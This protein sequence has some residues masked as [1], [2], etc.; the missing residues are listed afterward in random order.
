MWKVQQRLVRVMV[1]VIRDV[2]AFKRRGD[3][4][5][6]RPLSTEELSEA[7]RRWIEESQVDFER[8]ES[9]RSL[10]SQLNLFRDEDSLWHCDGRLANTELPYSTK[11][12]LLLP[13]NHSLTPLIIN[14]AHRRVLHEWRARDLDRNPKKILD[15]KGEEFGPSNSTPMCDLSQIRRCPVS[16]TTPTSFA[17]K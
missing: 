16:S 11:Y 2:K 4:Q 3:S 5:S 10:K 13:R 14:D 9:F 1:Y 7:E 17:C 12:P 15:R 8:E 6:N